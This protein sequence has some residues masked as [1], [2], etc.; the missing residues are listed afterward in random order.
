MRSVAGRRTVAGV[1]LTL[2][3]GLLAACGPDS[4]DPA[5]SGGLVGHMSGTSD[6]E[7]QPGDPDAGGGG[8]AVVP[9]EAM[10]GPFWD[11]TGA[12][13]VADPQ[14]WSYLATQLTEAQVAELGGEAASVDDDGDFRL[15][16]PPGEYAVCYWPG[17]LGGRVTGCDAVDLPTEG[18][19]EASW[20]EGGFHLGLAD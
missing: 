1:V 16:V 15:T 2:A 11:L 6:V 20:G 3:T 19:L 10:D 8:L 7:G 4:P 18:E 17:R 14:G 13:R 5:G 12:E 9:I